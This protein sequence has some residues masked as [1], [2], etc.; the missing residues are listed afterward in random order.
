MTMIDIV[1]E[2]RGL[3]ARLDEHK[4]E[5]ALC[6]GMAMGVHGFARTTIDID[7]L[8]L[9][10]SLNEVMAIAKDLGYTIRGK[11]LSFKNG[12]VE[13]RRISKLMSRISRGNLSVDCKK[14]S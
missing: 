10:E 2:L 7:L 12:A 8:I 6:G 13:I 14:C 11:D 1:E 5:Y 3:V 4:I 9:N